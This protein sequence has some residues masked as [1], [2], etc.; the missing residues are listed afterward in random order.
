MRKLVDATVITGKL[1]LHLSNESDGRDHAV[2]VTDMQRQLPA[3]YG[4]AIIDAVKSPRSASLMFM[5]EYRLWNG[6]SFEDKE[7]AGIT[8]YTMELAERLLDHY[9]VHNGATYEFVYSVLDT[10]A[11]KVLLFMKEVNL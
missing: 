2:Y 5:A 3:E 9:M 1:W 10:E 8:A 11:K 4:S 6:R 7:L